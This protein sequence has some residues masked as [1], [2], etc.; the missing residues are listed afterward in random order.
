MGEDL[1]LHPTNNKCSTQQT[2]I[3]CFLFLAVGEQESR[4][5]RETIS[6]SRECGTQEA[7]T[8]SLCTTGEGVLALC[9]GACALY[10]VEAKKMKDSPPL[11]I[12]SNMLLP[13]CN[14][15]I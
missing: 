4:D 14:V 6:L 5:R 9:I 10:M 3:E 13:K 12:R 2:F 7:V 11:S 1:I 15:Y 8:Y